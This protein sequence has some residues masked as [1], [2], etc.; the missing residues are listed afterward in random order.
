MKKQENNQR[1]DNISSATIPARRHILVRA[2]VRL[3]VAILS[4][5]AGVFW[6]RLSNPAVDSNLT[7]ELQQKRT[8][9]V[10]ETLEHFSS[11]S[12]FDNII[13]YDKLISF[14]NNP[15]IS[16]EFL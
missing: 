14:T 5:I 1:D 16:K 9:E 15:P 6:D 11:P 7:A 3:L 12:T 10:Q 13:D 4:F 8:D 2:L